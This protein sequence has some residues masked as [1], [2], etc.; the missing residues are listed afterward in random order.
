MMTSEG[1]RE[2]RPGST[3]WRLVIFNRPAG[4]W[5][6][7]LAEAQLDA[8]ESGNASRDEHSD[9]VYYGPLASL[10]REERGSI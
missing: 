6:G 2:G 1:D 3:R 8:I 7:T 4:P 5:R 9:Q 10:Q